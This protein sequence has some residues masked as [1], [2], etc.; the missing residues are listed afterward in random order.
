MLPK[1]AIQEFK[2]IYKAKFNI[3]LTDKEACFRAN[4]LFSL[5]KAI[6]GKS[7]QKFKIKSSGELLGNL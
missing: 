3:K 2:K 5:Y 6:Y 4:N 7:S 1:E